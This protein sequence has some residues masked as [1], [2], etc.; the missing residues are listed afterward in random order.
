M[1][2]I[3]DAFPQIVAASVYADIAERSGL[4]ASSVDTVRHLG[5]KAQGKAERGSAL[6]EY[7][8]EAASSHKFAVPFQSFF[9]YRLEAMSHTRNLEF[10]KP[11]IGGPYFDLEGIWEE[12]TYYEFVDRSVEHTMS[13]MVQEPYVNHVPTVSYSSRW[14]ILYS[15]SGYFPR[16]TLI[17]L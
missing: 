11:R 4:A 9:A 10:L 1:A 12:H 7:Y 15:L 17:F 2:P 16:G 3:L 13:T 8:Y 6:T 14:S 5:G